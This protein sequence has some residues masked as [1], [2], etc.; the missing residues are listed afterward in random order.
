M[1]RHRLP[2]LLVLASTSIGLVGCTSSRSTAEQALPSTPVATSAV[3][4]RTVVP[5]PETPV[6]T[7]ATPT[8][9][10]SSQNTNTVPTGPTTTLP[11]STSGRT[12][13]TQPTSPAQPS[14]SSPTTTT[15]RTAQPSSFTVDADAGSAPTLNVSLGATVTLRVTTSSE[16]SFHLHGYDIELGGTTV[17]FIFTADTAG[18]FVVESHTTGAVICTLVVG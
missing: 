14:S 12:A 17:T 4:D 1:N 15:S 8:T 5:T 6:S 7:I 16:Q 2:V 11:S 18:R 13:T 9:S 10:P 3:D